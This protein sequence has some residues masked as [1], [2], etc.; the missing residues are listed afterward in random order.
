MKN[1]R[2]ILFV[3]ALVLLVAVGGFSLMRW[4]GVQVEDP[5]PDT[6][7]SPVQTGDFRD[8]VA[9]RSQAE[10]VAF[11]DEV[12]RVQVS[13]SQVDGHDM[14]TL[15]EEVDVLRAELKA[16]ANS[17]EVSAERMKGW[18]PAVEHLV[19]EG[20]HWLD[21]LG[22]LAPH[23]TAIAQL[24]ETGDEGVQEELADHICEAVT[25]VKDL[26]EAECVNIAPAANQLVRDLSER[27]PACLPLDLSRMNKMV[28][29]YQ[30]TSRFA[31]APK[32]PRA[33]LN[34]YATWGKKVER[35]F[36]MNP[37]TKESRELRDELALAPRALMRPALVRTLSAGYQAQDELEKVGA[38]QTLHDFRISLTHLRRQ[39][40]AKLVTRRQYPGLWQSLDVQKADARRLVTVREDESRQLFESE[41]V[42]P[43]GLAASYAAVLPE[44]KSPWAKRYAHQ[45]QL[46]LALKT[47]SKTMVVIGGPLAEGKPQKKIPSI[48][49]PLETLGLEKVGAGDWFVG[50]GSGLSIELVQGG[51]TNRVLVADWKED[52]EKGH[53]VLSDI[54][55]RPTEVDLWQ[56][57]QLQLSISHDLDPN[58]DLI[59]D[60]LKIPGR[61]RPVRRQY[62]LEKFSSFEALVAVSET[63]E[64]NQYIPLVPL[65]EGAAPS[66][67]MKSPTLQ[68]IGFPPERDYRFPLKERSGVR[69]KGL[70]EGA[71]E[72]IER[73]GGGSINL[74]EILE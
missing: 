14:Q 4:A 37:T 73:I 50:S 54:E 69:A 67:P 47:R 72:L 27:H 43:A 51:K 52:L 34:D 7:I 58:R 20:S 68:L 46:W 74:K 17:Y 19:E 70:I 9:S 23:L 3:S 61:F 45:Q 16:L 63:M 44:L 31:Q 57:V 53:L 36:R 33:V 66:D 38:Y 21:S 28:A 60:G 15:P 65:V 25:L 40:E 8:Q 59:P 18:R 35:W 62:L 29:A 39:L 1:L 24:R 48:R 42:S 13:F 56:P 10:V 32:A 6:F 55:G 64:G 26:D 2:A 12:V 30:S 5:A 41:E 49:I 11:L 71:E 22:K